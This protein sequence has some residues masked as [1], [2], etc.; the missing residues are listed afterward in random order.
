MRQ[1]L[2][3]GLREQWPEEYLFRDIVLSRLLLVSDMFDHKHELRYFVYDCD[4]ENGEKNDANDDV[5]DHVL[6]DV[7]GENL[8][9]HE[10]ELQ[11][12]KGL[13]P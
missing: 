13:V 3:V 7:C 12:L 4:S 8:S 6:C 11:V 1:V 9:D 10:H 5:C 2:V